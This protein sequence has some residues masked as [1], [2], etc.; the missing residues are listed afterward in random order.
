MHESLPGLWVRDHRGVTG[1]PP[2]PGGG[3]SGRL[4]EAACSNGGFSGRRAGTAP[5][6]PRWA[7]AG[8]GVVQRAF[9]GDLQRLGQKYNNFFHPPQSRVLSSHLFI[10]I[11]IPIISN[12]IL[13]TLLPNFTR[14]A[15]FS[16]M[17]TT[18]RARASPPEGPEP[19]PHPAES[20]V[21][22]NGAFS[23]R[24]HVDSLHLAP[25]SLG[26]GPTARGTWCFTQ[27]H[28]GTAFS[29]PRR[30]R[31]LPGAQ[32]GAEPL[33]GPVRSGLLSPQPPRAPPPPPPAEFEA[34]PPRC[35]RAR[36]LPLGGARGQGIPGRCRAE[37]CVFRNH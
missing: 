13:T 32:A 10:I 29:C 1:Q 30:R 22:G 9:W 4:S 18:R 21:R 19:P 3:R 26:G 36:K 20:L 2:H 11:I 7:Q 37:L 34:R 24:N 6:Q 8:R 15:V 33:L 31:R 5:P 28:S 17:I 25:Q 23:R 14:N 35:G 16:H 27:A 12:P